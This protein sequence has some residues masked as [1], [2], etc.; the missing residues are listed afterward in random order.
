[1]IK[2]MLEVSFPDGVEEYIPDMLE[3]SEFLEVFVPKEPRV[4]EGKVNEWKLLGKIDRKW[5][6]S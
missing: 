1:M 2:L 6:V 5:T 3:K 4:L